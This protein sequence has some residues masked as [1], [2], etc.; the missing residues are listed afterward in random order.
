GNAGENPRGEEQRERLREAHEG[1]AQRGPDD[2]DEQNRLATE[3]IGKFAEDWGKDDLHAGINPGQPA[4]GDGRRME[5]L[6][7]KRQDRNDDAEAHQI[8]E[9]REEE[10]EKR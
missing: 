6:R 7:V 2:A 10:D 4:D 8:D 5:V 3:P 9:D 1:E